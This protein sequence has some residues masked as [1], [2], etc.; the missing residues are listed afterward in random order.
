MVTIDALIISMKSD[1]CGAWLWDPFYQLLKQRILKEQKR[2]EHEG[3]MWENSNEEKKT[4]VKREIFQNLYNY[5]GWSSTFISDFSYGTQVFD[6][7][8]R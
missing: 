7:S 6:I 5:K 3:F 1:W 8:S 4:M 2:D